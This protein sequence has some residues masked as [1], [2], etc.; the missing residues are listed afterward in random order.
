MAGVASDRC[1]R[2]CAEAR[3]ATFR[4]NAK[5]GFGLGQCCFCPA[6]CQVVYPLACWEW[7][8]VLTGKAK[9]K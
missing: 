1:C 8:A 9:E 4:L 7:P 6:W 2:Q 3:G 5:F